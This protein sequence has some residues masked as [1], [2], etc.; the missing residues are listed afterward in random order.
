LEQAKEINQKK[1][2]LYKDTFDLYKQKKQ[3]TLLITLFLKIY[4]KNKEKEN[5]DKVYDL[6]KNLKSFKEI[7]SNARIILD[8]N[9]YNPTHF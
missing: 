9:N 5:N 8:G 3:L 1:G 2:K 7:L 6:K 4:E